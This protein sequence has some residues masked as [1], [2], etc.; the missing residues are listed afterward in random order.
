M[1]NNKYYLSMFFFCL[2][3]VVCF[4]SIENNP[5]ILGDENKLELEHYL[6]T[7][8]IVSAIPDE[9]AGR[10]EPWRINLSDGKK[11]LKGWFK[12][13]NRVRPNIIPADSYKYELAAY[14][15]DKLLDFNIVPPTVERE[16]KGYIGSLQLFVEDCTSL[17]V[18]MRKK[19]KI[20]A[21]DKIKSALQEVAVFEILTYCQRNS[22][23]EKDI[24]IHDTNGK[25]CRVDFSQAFAPEPHFPPGIKAVKCSA[26]IQKSLENLSRD[27][28]ETALSPFLNEEEIRA[29]LARKELLVEK[30]KQ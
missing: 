6:R 15:L 27:K 10:S 23:S 26:K 13:I 21:S 19:D 12:H 1:N 18:L 22:E 20:L 4:G 11:R 17:S 24:L 30:L 8:R 5:G 29:L 3:V 25:V 7:A 14:E 2:S 28:I 16:I 9:D